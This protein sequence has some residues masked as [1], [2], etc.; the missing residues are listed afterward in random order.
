MNPA[1]DILQHRFED[2]PV[3]PEPL[4]GESL[5]GYL[6]R[7]LNRNGHDYLYA[8]FAATMLQRQTSMR[9]NLIGFF[10]VE[11]LSPMLEA[12]A[13]QM[14]LLKHFER[15]AWRVNSHACRPCPACLRTR[16]AFMAR[17][18]LPLVSVCLEHGCWLIHRCPSCYGSL[19][20]R[21]IKLNWTCRCGTA[22]GAA[23]TPQAPA[24]VMR[25]ARW[26]Q[27]GTGD[28]LF[29]QRHESASGG[30]VDATR[31]PPFIAKPTRCFVAKMNDKLDQ[32]YLL[33]IDHA[34]GETSARR[35]NRT[36]P[37]WR[38]PID[39]SPHL[40]T[41][42]ETEVVRVVVEEEPRRCVSEGIGCRAVFA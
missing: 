4:F 34:P 30:S 26:V 22:L 37:N 11:R 14:R 13:E 21:R 8:P 27:S 17:Q 3:R 6:W 2:F 39:T 15:G 28:W 32:A 23:A 7:F 12:E 42:A 1:R 19:P 36:M 5:Q 29:G 16:G 33:A 10:G 25:L 40:L 9:Q 38:H 20:W 24:W 41:Q 31:L 35:L 18:L